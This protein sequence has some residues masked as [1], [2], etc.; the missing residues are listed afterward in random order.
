MHAVLIQVHKLIF[1]FIT[2]QI[3]K[4][5]KSDEARE[6]IIIVVN[7]SHQVVESLYHV[8]FTSNYR[9]SFLVKYKNKCNFIIQQNTRQCNTYR[10]GISTAKYFDAIS[11]IFRGS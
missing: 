10:Y 7:K 11:T 2:F 6:G 5:T 1:H 8:E 4:A 3:W 9:R